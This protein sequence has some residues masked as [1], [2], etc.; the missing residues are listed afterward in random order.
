MLEGGAPLG[1]GRVGPGGVVTGVGGGGGQAV[2]VIGSDGKG[3]SGGGGSPNPEP[4]ALLFWDL[5]SLLPRS[6]L[7]P[8]AASAAARPSFSLPSHPSSGPSPYPSSPPRGPFSRLPRLPPLLSSRHPPGRAE[9][10]AGLILSSPAEQG[11]RR[12]AWPG[13]QQPSA[14]QGEGHPALGRP[15]AGGWRGHNTTVMPQVQASLPGT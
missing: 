11:P 8:F 6:A 4:Q 13:I 2:T 5:W 15:G 1:A 14:P 7:H 9:S 3:W 12:R 10:L